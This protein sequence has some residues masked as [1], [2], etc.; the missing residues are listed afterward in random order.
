[1]YFEWSQELSRLQ[2]QK[3]K[4]ES[5]TNLIKN[6]IKMVSLGLSVPEGNKEELRDELTRKLL[7]MIDIE[8]KIK[9]IKKELDKLQNK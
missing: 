5:Q 9:N 3:R 2:Q 6:Q 1:M 7:E 8:I 4:L